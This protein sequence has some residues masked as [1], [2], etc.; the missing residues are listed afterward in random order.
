MNPPPCRTSAPAPGSVSTPYHRWNPATWGVGH[1]LSL[2][3][4]TP[5]VLAALFYQL[6]NWRGRQAWAAFAHDATAA[7]LNLDLAKLAP[8]PVPDSQ[9]FA[10]TP[11]L[12][13]PLTKEA[14]K[15]Y[16][17]PLRQRLQPREL[18]D[19]TS[20]DT[21]FSS[22]WQLR[23]PDPAAHAAWRE[24]NG[25]A[26]AA[27]LAALAPELDEIARAAAERPSARYRYDFSGNPYDIICV[28]IGVL[29]AFAWPYTSRAQLMLDSPDASPA[30]IAA[31]ANDI[32][33][34]LR[35]ARVEHD[36]P[37][38]IAQLSRIAIVQ[39]ALAPLREGIA[40]NLWTAH[41]YA[42]FD[43]ALA[44]LDFL[45]GMKHG[46]A[47]ECNMGINTLSG[48][49]PY[50]VSG[51]LSMMPQPQWASLSDLTHENIKRNIS[52]TLVQYGPR[53][54]RLRA[55]TIVGHA[56]LEQIMPALDPVGQRVDLRQA[57]AA[58]AAIPDNDAPWNIM[59]RFIMPTTS[60]LART[61]AFAQS[62][63]NLA[64]AA[65][66]V[67]LHKLRTGAYPSALDEL[68]SDLSTAALHDLVTGEPLRYRPPLPSPTSRPPDKNS[69]VL[70]VTG[71]D[72]VDDG[73]NLHEQES[74]PPSW[75]KLK[76]W[77]WT[78][79]P[80]SAVATASAS[81]ATFE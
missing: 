69:Y 79:A 50:P 8:A 78:I 39:L 22:W 12:D 3:I 31:A 9:N 20:A 40:R 13:H 2:C 65:C 64:R 48:S 29:R 43:A 59:A 71:T 53:G 66:R 26:L 51:F 28:H 56:W 32:L 21:P 5:A 54:W 52:L 18:F 11:L 49:I 6:E 80:A 44:K 19:T 45:A 41:D 74:K 77:I 57:K 61:A 30:N 4:V 25:P 42:S 72:G 15:D 35:I 10:K 7:G 47:F 37:F 46:F 67:E 60:S 1:W 73:G 58:N 36:Q 76:D 33:T 17:A 34:T 81:G 70:Y 16:W 75:N 62:G 55:A 14:D 23:L 27:H 68:P 63:A 24:K 38:L